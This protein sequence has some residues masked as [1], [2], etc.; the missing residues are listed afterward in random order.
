MEIIIFKESSKGFLSQG[1]CIRKEQRE[2]KMAKLLNT[3]PP[4]STR[5]P[6]LGTPAL[7]SLP[8]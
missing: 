2:R 8:I 7:G 5:A 1:H 6:A 4:E 3:R